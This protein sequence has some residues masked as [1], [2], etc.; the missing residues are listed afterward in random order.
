MHNVW[1]AVRLSALELGKS[2]TLLA[3]LVIHAIVLGVAWLLASV[4]MGKTIDIVMH[5]GWMSVSVLG[6]LLAAVVGIQHLQQDVELRTIHVLLPRIGWRSLY[7]LARFAGMSLA[8]FGVYSAMV[9]MLV[10][11]GFLLGWHAWVP[12]AM[13][14]VSTLFEVLLALALAILF[15]NASSMFLAMF[16]TLNV[17]VCGRFSFVIKE[18]GESIGGFVERLTDLAYYLLPNFQA[19]NLREHVTDAAFQPTWGAFFGTL[20]YGVTETCL[21]LAT[22]C[23]IYLRKD[24][25]GHG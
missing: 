2:H 15:S 1:P 20:A 5:L 12:F 4:T 8:L 6:S 21:I 23:L 24:L 22:A 7:V 14:Y 17:L 9:A 13:A 25:I 11:V 3:A 19:I 10:A 18:F 16:M